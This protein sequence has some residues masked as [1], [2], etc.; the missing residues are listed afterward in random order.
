MSGVL[1]KLKSI[2]EWENI[3]VLFLKI[4]EWSESALETIFGRIGYDPIRELL[5]N[6]WFWIIILILILLGLIFRR[7]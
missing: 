6:P 4:Y 3:K 7:R 2:F 5:T 1:E